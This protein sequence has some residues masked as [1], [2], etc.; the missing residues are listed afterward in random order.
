[1]IFEISIVYSR[2][3]APPLKANMF[4]CFVCVCFVLVFYESSKNVPL[5]FL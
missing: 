4:S 1:M 3:V 2:N 5:H